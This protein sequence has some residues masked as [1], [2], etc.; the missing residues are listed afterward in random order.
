MSIVSHREK[1]FIVGSF[2]FL[3]EIKLLCTDRI[4]LFILAFVMFLYYYISRTKRGVTI[5]G[6]CKNEFLCQK[7]YL[8]Y[9]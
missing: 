9:E 6:P 1:F 3:I 4:T 8:P 5:I 7:I 2:Q